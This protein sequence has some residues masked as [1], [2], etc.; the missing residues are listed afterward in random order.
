MD[1]TPVNNN[2]KRKEWPPCR[3][4][5]Y[6]LEETFKKETNR[7]YFKEGCD[8]W[9]LPCQLCNKVLVYSKREVEDESKHKL[10]KGGAFYCC[11]RSNIED[12]CDYIICKDCWAE[13]CWKDVL[14]EPYMRRPTTRTRHV[15]P[16]KK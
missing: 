6:I 7:L 15:S 8:C 9:N 5:E 16:N 14:N 1:P 2:N 13:Y 11:N 10:V 12:P 4:D 3:H